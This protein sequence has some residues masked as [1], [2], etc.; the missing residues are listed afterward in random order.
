MKAPAFVWAHGGGA[1]IFDGPFNNYIMPFYANRLNC[2]TFNVD[3]RN[4]PETKCPGGQQD[5]VDALCH[6]MNNAGECGID[7][8][9]VVVSGISGGGWICV[10]ALNLM[11]KTGASELSKIKGLMV[12]T[13]MLSGEIF[14]TKASELKEFESGPMH[15]NEV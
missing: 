7:E 13:G 8:N 5:F 1:V 12:I 14:K 4:G 2:V 15:I 11:A 9:K 6:I 10:G 3:F